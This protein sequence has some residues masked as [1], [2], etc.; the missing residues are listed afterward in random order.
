MN[1]IDLSKLTI[2]ETPTKKIRANF[3]GTEKEFT[4][5]ALSDAQQNDFETIVANTGDVFRNRNA[6]ILLLVC[7]LGIDQET[8]AILYE[9]KHD[10]TVRVANEIFTFTKELNTSK[11]KE[12]EQAEKNLPQTAGNAP[13]EQ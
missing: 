9:L 7:G 13:A 2:K 8:A 4:I 3:D 6:H 1:E 12:A 10:E 11:E 5:A